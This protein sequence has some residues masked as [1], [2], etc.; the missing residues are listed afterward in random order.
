MTNL[1]RK[2]DLMKTATP[3][4]TL[5]LCLTSAFFGL[6]G[7]GSNLTPYEQTALQQAKGARAEDFLIVDC[8]LPGQI[9]QLGQSLTYVSRREAIKT[10][11]RDCELRGGEYVALDPANL[12]TAL[13]IWLPL[14]VQ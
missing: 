8:L 13:Q 10:S 9:R 11:S 5:L 6:T 12:A 14:A 2:F 3:R 1:L 7:C 4:V